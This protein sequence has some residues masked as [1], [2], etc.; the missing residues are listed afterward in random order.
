MMQK[1]KCTFT[2]RLKNKY[3]TLID[4]T[5]AIA[6]ST[7]SGQRLP[8]TQSCKSQTKLNVKKFLY[9]DKFGYKFDKQ[10][11]TPITSNSAN[12]F[13]LRTL[14]SVLRDGKSEFQKAMTPS[15]MIT[16]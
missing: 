14:A 7:V 16:S 11:T 15:T 5:M 9:S 2:T 4:G 13:L 3:I 6:S 10:F 12:W 8:S 1:P